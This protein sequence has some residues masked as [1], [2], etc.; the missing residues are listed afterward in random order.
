MAFN[1]KEQFSAMSFFLQITI[2][3]ENLIRKSIYFF[4]KEQ[5]FNK[6]LKEYTV[7]IIHIFYNI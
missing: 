4:L 6:I 3:S 1:H 5:E 7:L 2:N